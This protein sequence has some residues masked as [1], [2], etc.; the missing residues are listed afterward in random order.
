MFHASI[1][2]GKVTHL[3]RSAC[4]PSRSERVCS[5]H[6]AIDLSRLCAAR[7]DLSRVMLRMWRAF[8]PPQCSGIDPRSGSRR[9]AVWGWR[10]EAGDY[11]LLASSARKASL[12]LAR[13]LLQVAAPPDDDTPGEP[14]DFRTPCPCC[15][16]RM[17]VIEV[18]KRW[19][20]LR[21]PP[22][23]SPTEAV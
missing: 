16:G 9:K 15:G 22:V 11:G 14:E 13:E 3:P 18:F 17:I 5:R 12:A 1:I 2:A 19:R 7:P 23:R 6:E 21:G 10:D 4:A 8:V 20:Q